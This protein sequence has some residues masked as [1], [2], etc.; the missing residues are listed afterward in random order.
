METKLVE[1]PNRSVDQLFINAKF[2]KRKVIVYQIESC[3][4]MENL[5]KELFLEVSYERNK[6][7]EI[8]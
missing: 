1:R 8:A 3:K 5:Y 2:D 4:N 7:W 6:K